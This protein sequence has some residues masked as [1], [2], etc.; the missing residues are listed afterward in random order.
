MSEWRACGGAR[1]S[2]PG[3]VCLRFFLFAAA[4][5]LTAAEPLPRCNL[6]SGWAQTGPSRVYA[7]DNLYD[8]MDG[9]SEGYLIYGFKEMHGVTCKSGEIQFVL[10]I[11]DMNDSEA[12]YGLFASNRD[13][14]LPT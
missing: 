6:Q 13:P 11:S 14:R 8:Y 10:D 7:A 4:V 12:A 5:C 2:S 3:V 9:N 1:L